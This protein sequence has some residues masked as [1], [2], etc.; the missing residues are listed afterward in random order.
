MIMFVRGD[1]SF[2]SSRVFFFLVYCW[3]SLV[4][5]RGREGEENMMYIK[6]YESMKEYRTWKNWRIGRAWKS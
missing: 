6:F 1:R 4:E 2:I 5:R 3:L